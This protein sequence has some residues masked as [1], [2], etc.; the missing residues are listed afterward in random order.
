ML[1]LELNQVWSCETS[2]WCLGTR[3]AL[4]LVFLLRHCFTDTPHLTL[5]TFDILIAMNWAPLGVQL[6]K[7]FLTLGH[8]VRPSSCLPLET[9]IH[10]HMTP[11][12]SDVLLAMSWAPS[13]YSCERSPSWHLGTQRPSFWSY[14]VTDSWH[15][16]SS[17]S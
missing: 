14:W 9:L 7:I 5:L 10:W 2:S 11:S 12:T 1:N 17:T 8:M 3:S 15:Q 16:T 6:W 4:L 13:G